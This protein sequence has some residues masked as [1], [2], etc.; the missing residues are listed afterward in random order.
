MSWKENYQIKDIDPHIRIEITC[1]SCG[2]F[3][4]VTV[5]HINNAHPIRDYYLDEFE[6]SRICHVY[7]CGGRCRI[8]LPAT[9]VT[10]GFQGGLA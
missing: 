7:G 3:R 9:S 5:G 2:K 4:F 10:E 1:K 6:T 8:A